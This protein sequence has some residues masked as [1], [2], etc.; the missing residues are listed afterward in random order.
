MKT[1]KCDICGRT[2]DDL[3]WYYNKDVYRFKA[4]ILNGYNTQRKFDICTHCLSKIR[5]EIQQVAPQPD[6]R[7]P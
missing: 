1:I 2:S 3:K 5:D 6:V 4:T 7:L